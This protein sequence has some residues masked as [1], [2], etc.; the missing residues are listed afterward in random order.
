MVTLTITVILLLFAGHQVQNQNDMIIGDNELVE[1]KQALQWFGSETL[2]LTA[3][4]KLDCI[5]LNEQTTLT[6]PEL[7]RLILGILQELVRSNGIVYTE[8]YQL[9][10]N[11]VEISSLYR[12]LIESRPEHLQSDI[13][14]MET[15]IRYGKPSESAVWLILQNN[16]HFSLPDISATEDFLRQAIATQITEQNIQATQTVEAQRCYAVKNG[17]TSAPSVEVYDSSGNLITHLSRDDRMEVIYASQDSPLNG[18]NSDELFW[19]LRIVWL[20]G[21]EQ[22]GWIPA[23]YV[24]VYPDAVCATRGV[25]R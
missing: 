24:D 3:G 21:R 13:T 19:I 20:D 7:E 6:Q 15:L 9:P 12:D 22:L 4:R 16:Q 10:L 5:R 23:R 25:P 2:I 17:N 11:D 1:I 18:R 14:H 8:R